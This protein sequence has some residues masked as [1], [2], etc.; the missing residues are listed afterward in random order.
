LIANFKLPEGIDNQN[1]A[2]VQDSS[3]VMFLANRK[4]I[5]SFDGL[6]W[7][8]VNRINIPY[9][10]IYEPV[11]KHVYAGCYG[12]YGYLEKN[13]FG[14]FDYHDI[15]SEFSEVGAITKILSDESNLYFY[16]DQTISRLSIPDFTDKKIWRS[17]DNYP[18]S[19]MALL[20]GRIY[21]NVKGKG[22]HLIE[23]ES[24]RLIP[25]G[26]LIDRDEII[27]TL[28]FDQD[29]V[30]IATD[31]SFL[32]LFNGNELEDFIIKDEDYIMES[33]LSGGVS[34]SDN[35]IALVTL[36][37]GC[38][39]FNKISGE[40]IY[41]LNHQ[42]G[43]PDDEIYAVGND[44]SNG[45]WL[46]H[47][48]GTTRIDL[49]V[50]V[51]S[52][53]SYPG[54]EGNLIAVL[55]FDNTIYVSTSEGVYYL[56]EVKDF[57]EIEIL[58]KKKDPTEPVD[59]RKSRQTPVRRF[60][61]IRLE[62]EVP[63]DVAEEAGEEESKEGFFSRLFKK[64]EEKE[65]VA[66]EAKIEEPP[67]EQAPV[68]EVIEEET[69]PVDEPTVQNESIPVYTTK[70]TYA[71]QSISHKFSKIEN[72]DDKCK[73]LVRF[74]DQLL[75]ATN[76]GLY[77]IL[78]NEVKFI[79]TYTYIHYIHPSQHFPGLFYIGTPEGAFTINYNVMNLF[80]LFMKQPKESG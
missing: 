74:R 67:V 7:S 22:L 52:Y 17:E 47:E 55:D 44:Q 35:K 14:N 30:L 75:V 16:S 3:G 73:Q 13:K 27:F 68:V 6:E 54:L 12:N 28:A 69:P 46:S 11:T 20:D 70:R 26:D 53:S 9:S 32:Y 38:L 63:P 62:P 58:V 51:W 5:L 66:T 19:G 23:G 10:L 65:E 1:W 31:N 21:V 43:L 4:G 45:L 39:I 56:N 15:S 41:T 64:K 34:L 60:K 79:A 24:F 25:G 2:I 29:R 33:V 76:T 78:N 72:L 8:F 48:F 18:F 61:S 77:R 50:P 42:T 40:T 80:I 37:G 71:L 59:V 57:K 49:T 36:T